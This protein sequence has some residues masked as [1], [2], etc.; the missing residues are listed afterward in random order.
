MGCRAAWALGEWPALEAFVRGEH[1]Q[2]RKH[3]VEEGQGV[4]T[5]LV[6]EAVVATQR[7]RLD[8]VRVK[9]RGKKAFIR[10]K[11]WVTP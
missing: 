2:A 8:D 5:C 3:L 7:G 6:L 1:M 9:M 11:S 4:E 10:Y